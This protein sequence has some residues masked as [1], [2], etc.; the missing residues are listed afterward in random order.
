[1]DYLDI[2]NPL[3]SSYTRWVLLLMSPATVCVKRMQSRLLAP[4]TNEPT[5][6]KGIIYSAP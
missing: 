3:Y 4:E 6:I 1:M 2:N 5:I